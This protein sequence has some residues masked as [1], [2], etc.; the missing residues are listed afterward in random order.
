[1]QIQAVLAGLCA[2]LA[3]VFAKLAMSSA[4]AE[5]MCASASTVL[6]YIPFVGQTQDTTQ[7]WCR[8]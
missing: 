8:V 1:M 3:S 4:E 6:S 2:A 5:R 7:F